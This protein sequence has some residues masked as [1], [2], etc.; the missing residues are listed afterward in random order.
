MK[1]FKIAAALAVIIGLAL[2]DACAPDGSCP[3]GYHCNEFKRCIAGSPKSKSVH[4][5]PCKPDGSCP[6]GQ[7]CHKLKRCINSASFKDDRVKCTTSA[8][9]N[10]DHHCNEFHFCIPGAP[11]TNQNPVSWSIPCDSNHRCT[12]I[13]KAFRCEIST[14]RCVIDSLSHINNA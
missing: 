4:N 12:G 1:F 6:A 2:A 5:G 10:A 11:R 8:D 3:S 14:N 7:H 13:Y 9:C